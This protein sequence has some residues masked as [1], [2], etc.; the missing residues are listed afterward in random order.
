MEVPDFL[1]GRFQTFQSLAFELKKR[2][3]ALK[4]KFIDATMDLVMDVK[5]TETE[6]WKTV[7]YEDASAILPRTRPRAGSLTRKQ[8]AG[9]VGGEAGGEETN[10]SDSDTSMNDETLVDLT[11]SDENTNSKNYSTSS[12]SFL[13]TNARSLG[14]KMESLFDCIHEK[15]LDLAFI[16]ETW[17]QDNRNGLENL[18]KCSGKYSLGVLSRCRSDHANNGRQYGGVAM[19]FRQKSSS[20]EKFHLINPDDHEVLAAVGTVKGIKGKIFCL[21]VYEPPNL[22]LLRARQLHEY[23]SDVI[24]EAKRVF[25]D[26]TLVLAGDFNHWPIEEAIEDHPDM[27]E[28]CH[29]NTRG[30]RAI[31]RTFVNFKRSVVES[32]TLP[33]LESEDGRLSDHRITYT[34][35]EFRKPKV[36][37]IAYSYRHYTEEG[38]SKFEELISKQSWTDVFSAVG[39]SA[40]VESFQ[41]ILETLMSLCFVVKTT[42]RRSSDPPW[43]NC[44]IRKLSKKRRKVY[45][46]EGRSPRWKALKKQCQDLYNR[47]AANYMSEQKRVLTAPD[48]SRSF[49]KNVRAYQSREKP[50]QF[51]VRDLYPEEDDLTIAD[52]LGAYFNSISSEF[53][54]LAGVTVPETDQG[55]LPFLSIPEVAGR[56]IKFRKPKSRVRGDIFPALVSRTSAS[57][58]IPLTHIFNCITISHQWPSPWKI[59][60]VTPIPK[61]A[62]PQTINDLQNISCTQLFSKIYESFVLEWVTS[63]VKLR[64]NQY[65]GVKGRG[66]EHLLVNLWQRVL[67]NIEDSRASC[68]LTSIDFAKAFNRLDFGH[69]LRCLKAKGANGK[70]IKIIASFLTDRVMMVKVG[71]VLSKERPVLGGV[72]QGSLL[73]VFLFNLSIDDFEAFSPDVTP[74]SDPEH[75]PTLP[76]PGGPPD[77][78]VPPEPRGRDQRHVPPFMTALLEAFK[79]VDDNVFVEKLNFDTVRTDGHAFRTKEAVRTGNVVGRVV[80][81]AEAVGM[82]IHPDK[83]KT[84]CISELKSYNP[85]AYFF[86]KDGRK[87]ENCNY[88]KI[89]GISFSS[90]PDM[91]AQVESIKKAFRSRKW[92]LHHLSHR[93][94]SRADLLKVYKSAI[95]PLHDYCSCV[96]NSSLTYTQA[97]SLERLQAQS[98]K[99]IY[100]YSFSYRELLSLSGLTSLQ[101]RRD[102]RSLKFARKCLGDDYFKTWFPL[103]PVARLTR[104][105]LPYAEERARTKRLFNSPLFHMRRLLN[106]KPN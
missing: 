68:L 92:V 27:G 88:M 5:L 82:Q 98:L 90:D 93:G 66:S 89:L 47:R 85:K 87:V 48:A 65:G 63:Q 104:N 77:R 6:D 53:R 105:P 29:G 2:Y 3:P 100:G 94:F 4:R 86:D 50:P 18:E 95:L 99:A 51:D 83:T 31:D 102:Q 26:C 106:G 41:K 91:R 81:Q 39:S 36:P 80:H 37:T 28:V 78:P 42:T 54:G 10:K 55:F 70:L 56:L 11:D 21:T 72:P 61:K 97:S 69:C 79:Y 96:F 103:N 73:G 44:K 23:V 22:T 30:H 71:S 45:D 16:T 34:K 35:A 49:Y 101:E 32:G 33:P 75:T 12:L 74:Y 38:A 64:N 25:A 67:E 46:R 20:F 17:Y 8:L 7:Q 9:M 60:Y 15:N 52:K 43:V 84:M 40:K 1:R 76:A 13:N 24:G 57:L 19:F 14:P 58:S 59:E 62:V